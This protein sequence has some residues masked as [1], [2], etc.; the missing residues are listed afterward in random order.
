VDIEGKVA[1]VTGAARGIGRATAVALAEAGAAAVV[2]ADLRLAQAEETAQLVRAAGAQSLA[3]ETDIANT[4]SIQQLISET[5]G[6]FRALH[7]LHNNA[8]IGEAAGSWPDVRLERIEGIVD[9]NLRGL[10]VATK[11]AL[12]PMHRAGGGAIVN[13]ASGAA[14]MPLPPQAVYAATKAGV[15]HFTR[16]CVP[17]VESHGVRVSCVCPGLVRTEM[18]QETGVNGPH[19]WLQDVIDNVEML[20]PEDIARAVLTLIG[21]PDSAG[22]IVNLENAPNSTNA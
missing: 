16:S 22:K 12:E 19:E 5:E 13:I 8:A 9:I 21:A 1:I 14:F 6:R 4:D 2:V 20:E 15:V 11:L 17:L 3:L 18:V 7:I 10:I